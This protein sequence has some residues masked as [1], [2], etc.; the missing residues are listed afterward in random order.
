MAVVSEIYDEILFTYLQTLV[1]QVSLLVR[2][3]KKQSQRSL[4][5]AHLLQSEALC[6]R[7]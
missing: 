2:F 6:W 1:A 5:I 3:T 4:N 7:P